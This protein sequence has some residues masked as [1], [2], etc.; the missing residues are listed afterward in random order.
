[1]RYI[2]ENLESDYGKV[3]L[4]HTIFYLTIFKR[5]ISEKELTS[6][7][8]LDHAIHY[9]LYEDEEH[10]EDKEF[11]ISYWQKLKNDLTSCLSECMNGTKVICWSY[12]C[13]LESSREYYKDKFEELRK[14]K[15]LSA[16]KDDLLMNIIDYFSCVLYDKREANQ[17]SIYLANDASVT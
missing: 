17:Q 7:L 15:D 12:A 4:S 9:E 2:F 1:M 3:F 13:Y 16:Y 10:G 8:N 5:G 6:I 11:L 14:D